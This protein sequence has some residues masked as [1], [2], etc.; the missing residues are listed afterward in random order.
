MKRSLP[1]KNRQPQDKSPTQAGP[2]HG[3]KT[4]CCS[5][6]PC[7]PELWADIERRV[8]ASEAD[9]VREILDERAEGGD[10][11]ELVDAELF[12]KIPK[13]YHSLFGHYGHRDSDTH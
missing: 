2:G 9:R 3:V 10:D 4:I 6:P 8:G 11:V 12:Q 7:D 5:T 13:L 1:A